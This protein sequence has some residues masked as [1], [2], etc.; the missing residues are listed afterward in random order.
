MSESPASRMAMVE[1]RKSLPHAVPS[2]ICHT[3]HVSCC[4]P[5]TARL[6]A[7][8]LL[9]AQEVALQS[10][11]SSFVRRDVLMVI[12]AGEGREAHVVSSEMVDGS[13]GQHA[14]VCATVSKSRQT[15]GK[16]M[17]VRTL[18]LGFPQ[19]RRVAGDDDELSLARA[20]SLEGGFVAQSNLAGLFLR[21]LAFAY[22]R[23]IICPP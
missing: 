14:V 22:M 5:S 12:S 19:R 21:Q 23:R 4:S 3:G 6:L 8:L 7:S 16:L 15:S 9:R 13:L 2:S 20:K 18:K 11:D 10:R 17:A 1:H